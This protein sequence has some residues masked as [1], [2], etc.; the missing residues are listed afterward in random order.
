MLLAEQLTVAID[1]CS[2]E[3]NTMEVSGYRQWLGLQHSSKYLLLCSTE[4]E[5]SPKDFGKCVE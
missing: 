1:F 5:K 3:Q 2:I 4:E